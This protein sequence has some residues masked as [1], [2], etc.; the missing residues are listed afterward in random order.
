MFIEGTGLTSSIPLEGNLRRL[1]VNL[2]YAGFGVGTTGVATP[3]LWFGHANI[4][5]R[6][7]PE[8]GVLR[9][10]DRIQHHYTTEHH[11]PLLWPPLRGRRNTVAAESGWAQNAGCHPP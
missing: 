7:D 10:R 11:V 4:F 9:V 6:Y 3:R 2:R 8:A 1:D 5:A